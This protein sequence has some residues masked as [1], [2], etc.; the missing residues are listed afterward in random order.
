MDADYARAYRSLYE[1]HWWWRAR[2]RLILDTLRRIVPTGGWR[3]ILDVGCGDGLFLDRLAEIGDVEGIEADASLVSSDGRHN[4]RIHIGNFD[5]TFQPARRYSLVLMLDVVEHLHDP[6]G[7]LRHARALLEPAGVIMVT[8]P[9]FNVLWT[10]HDD[11]NHHRTR[12][13]TRTLSELANQA[14]LEVESARYFF[15][16]GYPAKLAERALALVA[17]A[18]RSGGRE[19]GSK[20]PRIPAGWANRSLYLLSRLEQRLTAHL[21]LPFGSSLML[22]ARKAPD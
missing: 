14:N 21:P 3:R 22:V 7:A 2:E 4:G 13:T 15:H 10:A 20:L 12:Y 1:R 8:V 11:L 18:S 9:A 5:E 16:W 6:V 17:P 19:S